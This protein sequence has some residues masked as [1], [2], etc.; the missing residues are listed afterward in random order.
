MAAALT[1]C[2]LA[3]GCGTA[4]LAAQARERPLVARAYPPKATVAGNRAAA[5]AEAARLLALT[6]LPPGAVRLARPPRSLSRNAIG[7]P[8]V[9]SL[10]DKP[11]TWRVRL[12]F[13]TVRAW[14]SAH[15]PRGLRVQG[16][17]SSGGAGGG[18]ETAAGT[19]YQGPGNAAWQSA[20]L[21]ISTAPDGTGATAI[22]ADAMIVWLDP[23]PV[24]S[25]PGAHPLRVTL[26]GGCPFSDSKVTGV[27]NP[28]TG[29]TRQLL[30]PGQPTAGLRC[31]YYG[32]NE[33]AF[34]LRSSRRLTAA[35]A[36][37][38]A[39]T[40]RALPLSHPDGEVMSCPNDD[41]SAEVLVL[42]YPGRPDVDLWIYL[43]GC[44]GVS[45]GHISA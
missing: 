28:G 7:S 43:T 40:M 45:N 25:G 11:M 14:L 23:R 6:R 4:H 3:T 16:W 26:A 32:L 37:R 31:R 42:S 21:D 24:R 36:R 27:T 29:L 8:M 39:R 38:A 30:P 22:R 5:R 12:P 13:G 18:Q 44:G 17:A 19:S 1:L 20:E 35:E 34:A 9:S 2:V 33:H 41:G 10:V 15:P